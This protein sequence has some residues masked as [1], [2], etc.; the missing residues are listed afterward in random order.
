M[1]K[2]A[3]R[4]PVPRPFDFVRPDPAISLR[5]GVE[6]GVAVARQLQHDSYEILERGT[7]R[8]Q[9]YA[10]GVKRYTLSVLAARKQAN[11]EP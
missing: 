5:K 4:S 2:C 6:V 1:E 3:Q 7:M 10:A 8:Q 9:F 11:R